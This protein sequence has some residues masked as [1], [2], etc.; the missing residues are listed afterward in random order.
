[1][2][3]RP[4]RI[5]AMATA[6]VLASCA[7]HGGSV[8][9]KRHLDFAR[10]LAKTHGYDDLAKVVVDQILADPT[11]KDDDKGALYQAL[12]E[13]YLELVEGVRGK[14]ALLRVTELLGK[15]REYFDKYIAHPAARKDPVGL[16]NVRRRVIWISVNLARTHARMLDDPDVPKANHPK[17]IADATAAYKVAIK[18]FD[19]LAAQKR[20]EEAKLKAVTPKE[21]EARAK[22]DERYNQVRTE[23]VG[24]RILLNSV[25]VE[26]GKFLKANGAAVPEW[27]PLVEA[28]AKDLKQMLYDFTDAR[29]L[30]QI[31]VYYAEAIVELGPENDAEAL[32][33]LKEVWEAKSEFADHKAVP[34]KAM[35]IIAGVLFRQKKYDEV[36]DTL[37]TMI[38]ARTGGGWDPKT[39]K[40]DLVG[41]RVTDILKNLDEGES[42]EQY[43]AKALS[44]SF[45]LE[46][47][48]YAALA[49]AAEDA[50]KPSKDVQRLYRMAYEIG[51]GVWDARMPMEPKYVKLIEFWRTKSGAPPSLAALNIQIA[52]A[53]HKAAKDKTE[54]LRAARLYTEQVARTKPDPEQLRKVWEN[55]ARC[56]YAGGDHYSSYTVFTALSRWL[57]E[58]QPQ[59]YAYAQS[60]IQV[61]RNEQEAREKEKAGPA[62]LNFL[63]QVINAAYLNAEPLSPL[64]PG[65]AT[66][67]EARDLR[68]EKK[69][70]DA[71]KLLRGV[72][73]ES[74]AYP[75]ALHE[76]AL[77]YREM[78]L[79]LPR[80]EQKGAGGQKALKSA[81]DAFQAC[82]DYA[83]KRLP[84]LA[85]PDQAD[86]RKRVLDAA[87]TSLTVYCD[88]LL[89][90]DSGR[91][92]KV[93]EITTGLK[94][95]YPGIEATPNYGFLVYNRMRGAY[96]LATGADG[97][98]AAQG[99]TILEE[100]WKE[101]KTFPDF[102]YLANAC[103]MGANAHNSL[104]KGL[105]ERAK[106]TADP[107]AKAELEK[108]AEAERSR[109]LEFYLDLLDAAPLQTLNTYRYVLYQL[110]K[111][112]REPKSADY[113]KII[114][115]APKA[116]SLSSKDEASAAELAQV[117]ILLASAHCRLNN[118]RDAIPILEETDAPYEKEYQK[119]LKAYEAAKARYDA[120]PERHP[121]PKH[122]SRDLIQIQVREWLGRAY[123]ETNAKSKLKD[124]QLFYAD[125]VRMYPK[126][127]HVKHWEGL[128]YL[129]E[130]TRMIG[131][132]EEVQKYLFRASLVIGQNPVTTSKGTRQD[133]VALA[134]KLRKEIE[135]LTDAAR[136]KTLL[137]TMDLIDKNLSK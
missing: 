16:F 112:P 55:I 58:P 101:I 40:I 33:R 106:K 96:N 74:R 71:L 66:I 38:T 87:V 56:Y 20:D 133:F 48:A 15:A 92:A 89:E 43:D 122:P 102:K 44:A 120:E 51:V 47:D 61:M 1:M 2:L 11:I 108:Q 36:I 90:N 41:A 4:A 60:A 6:V 13:Y 52:D 62:E 136:R 117:R 99:M 42:P 31:N 21:K 118:W 107:A 67:G 130:A 7:A 104:A 75:H 80:E 54:Y 5:A 70:D 76:I 45:L 10:R 103:R 127:D 35:H 93:L 131:D 50:K 100:T 53:L 68:K 94:A 3:S 85:G 9:W 116:L 26:L 115:L 124:A 119:R 82:I 8:A 113:R 23:H 123:L 39:Q 32:E 49:K 91:A 46:T 126:P 135:A 18:D 78:Y 88:M 125:Q 129:C 30:K 105:E 73:P 114:E 81:L 95:T 86:D 110:D 19:A 83:K 134:A 128:Y 121:Q 97:P 111:R 37:D 22:W 79:A 77:T 98:Q 65:A 59:A 28:A 17:H 109:G 137:P 72:Q 63:K 25:R 57:P 24:V 69:F 84:E 27:K 14:D 34:C 64:G 29:G 12:G 132:Y